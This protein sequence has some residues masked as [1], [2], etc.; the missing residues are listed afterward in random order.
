M[1]ETEIRRTVVQSQP[2]QIAHK[3]LSGKKNYKNRPG[4]VSQDQG[5]EFK[6]QYHTYTYTHT[7]TNANHKCWQ[8]CG[9][10]GTLI[11]FWWECKLVQPLLKT[12]WKLLKKLKLELPYDTATPLLEIHPKEC[13][14]DY[15]KDSAHQCLLQHYSQSLS[16]GNSQ[17]APLLMNGLRKCG[18]YI[19]WNFIQPQR[20]KFCLLQVN[21]QNWRI[22]S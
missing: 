11:N 12:I 4:K 19:K 18:I 21:G 16:Y 7:H 10:N 2:R 14:S 9:Q 20:I 15:N 1:R 8:G 5:P 6:P 3:T 17:D 22:S 13:K